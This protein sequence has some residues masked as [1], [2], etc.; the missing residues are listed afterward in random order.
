MLYRGQRGPRRGKGEGHPDN[1]FPELDWFAPA[2]FEQHPPTE[3]GHIPIGDL[4]AK[5]EISC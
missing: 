4:L 1:P 5:V 2:D 3:K